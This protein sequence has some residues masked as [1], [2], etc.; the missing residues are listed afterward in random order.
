MN[1]DNQEPQPSDGEESF[2]ELLKQSFIATDRI[3]SGDKVSAR[4]VKI[5]PEWVFIDLGGKSEGAIDAR[6]FQDESGTLS[7]GEGDTISAYCLASGHGEQV[8][9]T[10]LG[11][12]GD[13]PDFLE[14]A[15]RSGIPVEGTV[16]QEIK[17]GFSIKIAG[18]H[19]AFCPYSQMGLRRV[20]DPVALIG[21]KL[22]FKITSYQ[23]NGRNI[24]VSHRAVLEQ[25]RLEQKEKLKETLREGQ[26]VTGTV[27]SLR[28]FGAFVDLGGADGLIP[29]AELGWSRVER[30]SDVLA[31]GQQVE[32]KIISIDWDQD[33]ISLSLK[34]CLPD[35]WD[36]A[37]YDFAP[38]S[39]HT[40][41]VARV[42]KFG[43]FV[44]LAPGID[45]LLHV[46]KIN[47]SIDAG[48][49]PGAQVAV[50]VKEL[51]RDKRRIALDLAAAAEAAR[52]DDAESEI[53]R[54][55]YVSSGPKPKG[56]GSLGT[57]G[58]ALR[59]QME[60]KKGR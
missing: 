13:A 37:S 31:P 51:D 41:T 56:S 50:I 28:D 53:L 40:G 16:E 12:G 14:E 43:A 32:V 15:H 47:K 18:A 7:V 44:T 4:I 52:E 24:I 35:P 34:A 45:G 23:E 54:K 36:S 17:G 25:E 22:T 57:L 49:R 20:E 26:S 27:S 5:T 3:K 38:G 6:E 42:T 55:K 39:T 48:I 33:R 21:Q 10:R 46:S 11:A 8:F 60:K 9:S 58:D 59:R 29:M 30:A 1:D 19:R 2:A